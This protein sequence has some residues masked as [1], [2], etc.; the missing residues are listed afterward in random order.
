MRR[1]RFVA[2]LACVVLATAC[3]SGGTGSPSRTGRNRNVITADELGE[4]QVQNALEAVRQLRPAW[5]TARGRTGLP[6]IYRNSTLWGRD[7]SSLQSIQIQTIE[8][9]RYFN[10][11]DATTRWGMGVSGGVI[12]VMTR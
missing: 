4:L 1:T 2:L 7:P 3:A 11:A 12:Q 5:L 6:V 9:I 8:E 10:A